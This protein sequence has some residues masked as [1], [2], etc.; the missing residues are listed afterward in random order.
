MKEVLAYPGCFVCGKQNAHGLQAK[1]YYDGDK[2]VTEVVATKA[3]EGYKGICHGGIVASLLDEVMI[4]AILA[5]NVY[6]VT[7]EMTVRFKR[8]VH[9]GEKI[10]LVGRV[11]GTRGRHFTTEGEAMGED[12]LLF[13]TA[14][15]TYLEA[16]PTLKDELTRSEE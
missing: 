16:R 14:T 3:F 1:F 7:A 6:S 13:A 4:K 10:H 2:A 12:G 9:T 8:P 11:T 5:R 15:G